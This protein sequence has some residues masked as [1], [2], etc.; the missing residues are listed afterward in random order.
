MTLVIRRKEK[1]H[2]NN[3]IRLLNAYK[4]FYSHNSKDSS[5]ISH[6]Q[7]INFDESR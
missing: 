7:K 6:S 3:I 5:F 1:E 4:S 2:N